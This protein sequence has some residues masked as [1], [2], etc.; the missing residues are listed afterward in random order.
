[1]K[2]PSI[3]YD[4]ELKYTVND[5]GC[6]LFAG[7]KDGSGYGILQFKGK[8]YRA[9]RYNFLRFKG[10]IEDGLVVRHTCKKQRDCINPQHLLVGTQ[11]DNIADREYDKK[12]FCGGG[13]ELTTLN[14]YT[15]NNRVVCK[16]CK[17][18]VAARMNVPKD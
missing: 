6:W 8:T 15:W 9:H 16:V 5:N 1:M 18:E 17:A 4:R 3:Y 10:D 14:S 13:H 11:Q 2:L 7:C 12:R